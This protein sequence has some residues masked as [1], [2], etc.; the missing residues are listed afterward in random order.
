M[1]DNTG[2]AKRKLDTATFGGLALAVGGI[3]GGL[4]LEGGRLSDISQLTAALIVLG[5]TCGAVMVTTPMSVLKAAVKKLPSVLWTPALSGGQLLEDILRLA[6]KAR[7]TGLISLENE[8]EEIED[9]FFQKA[10]RLAVDGTDLKIVQRIMDREMEAAELNGEAEAKV[11]EAAGGYAPTV[12]II[13]AVLGLIQVMK[14]LE[15]IDA[16]GHGIA[17]AFVATVYGVFV[18]NVFFIPVATKLKA[19]LHHS[20]QMN[21]MALEGVIA[22]AEGLNPK[23]IE[24]QLERFNP[25]GKSGGEQRL[26]PQSTRERAAA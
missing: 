23:L 3:L 15:D 22:V 5:G 25:A 2:K 6:A 19:R 4:L 9:P 20:I 24:S 7:R 26:R 21:E 16:V 14:H 10:L 8:A 13:G 12:G 18:A 17:V 11:F 1:A